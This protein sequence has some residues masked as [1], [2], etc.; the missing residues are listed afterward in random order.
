M[1]GI[2]NI[3][4]LSELETLPYFN[5]QTA[6][7]L[8][9]KAGRNLDRKIERITKSGYL[10]R[11]KKGLYT[12]KNYLLA[13]GSNEEYAQNF[14][15]NLYFPSYL[16]LEYVLSKENL[17][18]ESVRVYTSITTKNTRNIENFLGRFCYQNITPK[19]FCGFINGRASKAKALFDYLYLKSNLDNDLV[20]DLSE[21]LRINW[22]N[23]S[24]ADL[25]EFNQF[26]KLINSG[27]M[28]RILKIIAN[29]KK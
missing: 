2:K 24:V 14:A 16:S 8:L 22:E 9:E 17:I 20:R 19:L 12:T 28:T 7:I 10:L 23:F 18:P 29:I 27:K 13:K 25:D 3:D 21:N 1:R 26:V 6:G 4:N 5:K 11:L 15:Q